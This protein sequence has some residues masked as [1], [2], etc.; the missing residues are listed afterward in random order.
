MPS[1]LSVGFV[2]AVLSWLRISVNFFHL[3]S[4]F[5]ICGIGL[6]YT[7]FHLN[8]KRGDDL[9]TVLFS[10]L[11]TFIGF[12]LLIFTHFALIQSFGFVLALGLM[13]TYLISLFFFRKGD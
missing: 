11:T 3:L 6:D 4:L 5:I 1:V 2:L 12:G 7:I 13:S 10:F 8:S 9:K